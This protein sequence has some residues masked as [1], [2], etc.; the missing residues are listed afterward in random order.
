M[1]KADEAGE[2]QGWDARFEI[3][4]ESGVSMKVCQNYMKIS[5]YIGDSAQ[6]LSSFVGS[7]WSH[8]EVVDGY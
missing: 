8:R 7:S 3:V 2:Y 4:S 1:S 5:T 6:E